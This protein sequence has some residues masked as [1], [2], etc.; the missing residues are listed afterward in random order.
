[1]ESQQ[2]Q[3]LS[4]EQPTPE[5][6][7]EQVSQEQTQDLSPQDSDALEVTGTEDSAEQSVLAAA[8]ETPELVNESQG[9]EEQQQEVD[10]EEVVYNNL[11][12]VNLDSLSSEAQSHVRPIL[13]LAAREVSLMKEQ[14]E[15]LDSARKEF[16][17]LI[18][19]ME[20]SGYD[21]K[22]LQNRIDEQNEIIESVSSDIIDTAWQAFTVTHPEFENIP[23][24]ARDLFAKELERLY[25][26]YD[27]KTVLDRMNNAYDY[28]LWKSG[29]DKN[30]LSSGKSVTVSEDTKNI[31]Q[32]KNQNAKKHAVI[33]DGRIATSAPV[34]SVDELDWGDVLDRH[35]HLLD[36]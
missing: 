12:D 6:T 25:E 7:Q 5:P 32:E 2:E 17:E 10:V 20:S 9:V 29:V 8:E 28:S 27:G 11:S 30:S 14:K 15:A 22:P 36:R 35:A 1:M 31:S 3:S 16:T 4:Q 23:D 19:A 26:R 33:A 24:N 13:E 18:D 21:V 34:R